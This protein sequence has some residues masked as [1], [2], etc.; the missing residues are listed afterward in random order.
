MKIKI[1]SLVVI[2]LTLNA[3]VVFKCPKLDGSI[4]SWLPYRSNEIFYFQSEKGIDTL[5][6]TSYWIGHY[7]GDLFLA[8]CDGN[9]SNGL[10]LYIHS[11]K[12][13]NFR[14]HSVAENSPVI[15][16]EDAEIV[17]SYYNPET[18]QQLNIYLD[19]DANLSNSQ[20]AVFV[21]RPN[22][23]FDTFKKVVIEKYIG[24]TL[25][26]EITLSNE[27]VIWEIDSRK[28]RTTSL[29]EIEYEVSS[30]GGSMSMWF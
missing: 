25:I 20:K 24:F 13:M 26:Q 6:I 15:R 2:V 12:T 1:L 7:E 9:C 30:C 21:V 14:I 17:V 27:N 11:K 8:D 5:K 28:E 19:Y 4:L 18:H 3:C 16:M 23:S 22:Q 10:D 29:A